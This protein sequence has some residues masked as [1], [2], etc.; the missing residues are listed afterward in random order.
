MIQIGD[1][2]NL[3]IDR[4]AGPGAFL[5]DEE[6][7]SILLPGK[8]LLPSHQIDDYIKVFVYK[9]NEGRPIATT[10]EPHLTIGQFGFLEINQLTQAGAFCD[11]GIQK[12]V[13]LPFRE[14]MNEPQAG[15]TVL[16]YM[17]LDPKSERL[18]ASQRIH[19]YLKLHK[20]DLAEK[21]EV[22][23]I[24]WAETPMGYKCIVNQKYSGILYKNEVFGTIKT[25][26]SMRAYV[27]K[28]REDGKLDLSLQALGVPG[29]EQASERLLEAIKKSG[30][31]LPL[32]DKSNPEAIKSSLGMSKKAFKRAAGQLYKQKLIQISEKGIKL[33]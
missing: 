28:C 13:L 22:E 5:V 7:E 6:E 30:G 32:H 16:V 26:G 27:K 12:D 3:R 11:M 33:L 31:Q 25:D 15:D 2:N 1:Y 14:Q 24:V 20:A 8:Y 29:L 17:F 9:D 19:R 10:L 21:Q 23:I 4:I 18:V